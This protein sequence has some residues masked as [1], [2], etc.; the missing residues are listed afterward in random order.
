MKKMF[1]V[2]LVMFL[3]SLKGLGLGDDLYDPIEISKEKRAEIAPLIKRFMSMNLKKEELYSIIGDEKRFVNDRKA[4]VNVIGEIGDLSDIPRLKEMYKEID[5]RRFKKGYIRSAH[6]PNFE[7]TVEIP[8]AIASIYM[9]SNTKNREEM[10]KLCAKMIIECRYKKINDELLCS[11]I[12]TLFEESE[13]TD[14][15]IRLILEYLN[16]KELRGNIIGLINN[17][18]N[19]LAL[20]PLINVFRESKSEFYSIRY[21][22][23]RAI[24]KIGDK[25]AIPFLKEIAND[26]N[27]HEKV[28]KAAEKAI[29]VLS[30]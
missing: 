2:Y 24:Q 23:V 1:I 14:D 19:K 20:E 9:K 11:G 29:E 10:I 26:K 4:A 15:E 25:S 8:R 18:P 28:R 27:E 30:K 6:D 16:N 22:T 7:V 13:Y 21:W 12:V 5:G 17:N 3:L